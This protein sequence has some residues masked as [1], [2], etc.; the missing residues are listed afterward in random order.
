MIHERPMPTE[1]AA[2]FEDYVSRVPETDPIPVLARQPDELMT[3]LSPL[4]EEAASLRYEP[5]KWSIREL[6]GHVIDSERVMGYRALCISRGETASLPGFEEKEYAENAGHDAYTL[7]SLLEE[8]ELVRRSHVSMLRHLAP[9]AWTRIGTANA[10]PVS[11]RA[12]AFVMAGHVRH[13]HSVLR[14]RYGVL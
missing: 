14:E 5:G 4:S 2:A 8:F 6:L 9:A 3:S 10:H 1:Y 12:L 13:H 7:R 11:V